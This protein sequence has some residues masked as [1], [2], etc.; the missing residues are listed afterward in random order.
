[1]PD[2]WFTI[3]QV[4][5]SKPLDLNSSKNEFSQSQI[6]DENLTDEEDIEP[7]Y[8]INKIVTSAM[9]RR[10]DDHIVRNVFREKRYEFV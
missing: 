6:N 8:F 2:D 1:M 9:K 4:D 10:G 3:E 7:Q 5:S